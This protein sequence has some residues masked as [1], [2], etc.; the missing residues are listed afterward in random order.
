MD[1]RGRQ[2]PDSG[3]AATFTANFLWMCQGDDCDSEGYTPEWQGME[4]F[5]GAHRSPAVLAG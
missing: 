1:H 2:N 5:Q 3:E 4:D